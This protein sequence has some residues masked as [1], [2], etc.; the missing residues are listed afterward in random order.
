KVP[1]GPLRSRR[2]AQLAARLLTP[3]D[4]ERPARALPPLR[5][6]LA[7]L[8]DARRFE[9][10][11]RLRDRIEAL[12]R[13]CRELERLARLRRARCC[14]VVPGT[15]PGTARGYFVAGG[16]IA[17]VRPLPPGPGAHLE[18]EAGLAAAR[19]ALQRDELGDLDELFLL[20]TF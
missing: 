4:L 2:R 16:R 20:G 19:R 9:D 6:K 3:D 5:R 14:L 7:S 18:V 10:A 1:L 12:E 8:A 11:A 13:V 15:V 17:A